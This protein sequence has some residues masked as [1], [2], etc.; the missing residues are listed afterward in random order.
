MN[1]AYIMRGL[2]GSGKSTLAKKLAGSVGSIHATDDLMVDENGAYA[3]NPALLKEKHQQNF[4]QFQKSI[5]A[6][7]EIVV[8]DA[9]NSR[10]CEYARY[11][12]YAR[13]R[14]YMVAI[15]SIPHPPLAIC[16]A[17]NIH[18]VPEHTVRNMIKRWE[19]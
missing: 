16:L 1:T 3:F 15:V 8:Y 14:G 17:R 7:V 6:G 9:T 2:P 18:N 13:E 5:D 4:E 12:R 19:Y 11:A 10:H